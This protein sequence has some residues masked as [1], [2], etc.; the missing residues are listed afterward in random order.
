MKEGEV[1]FTDLLG[2]HVTNSCGMVQFIYFNNDM[3]AFLIVR[4]SP[5]YLQ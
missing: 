1:R 3:W 2:S 4:G 5:S